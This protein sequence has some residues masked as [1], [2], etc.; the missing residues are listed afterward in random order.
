MAGGSIT[1]VN[2]ND[3]KPVVAPLAFE[4]IGACLREAGWEVDVLDLAFADDAEEAIAQHFRTCDPVAVGVT[5]RNT[6]DCYFA[7]QTSC[8]PGAQDAVSRIKSHTDAPV[9]LGG[10]G[11]SLM[12]IAIMT[13]C[14]VDYGIQGE[15]EVALP[16]L[17]RAIADGDEPTDIPGVIWRRE[18]E[19]VRTPP[20][21]PALDGLPLAERGTVDNARYFREGGM[22]GFETKR[23]CNRK[24][25]YCAD[26]VIKGREIRLR[27]PASVADELE[28]LLRLGIT[29]FHTCDSEFNNQYRHALAVCREIIDRGLGEKI[30]WY[31]YAIPRPF[32][33]ELAGTMKRAGCVGINFGAD[34]GSARMLSA[35]GRDFG[36]EDLLRTAKICRRQGIACMYDLL[37]GGPGETRESVGESIELM[38]EASP[39]RVGVA[40]G[41]RIYPGTRLAEMVATQGEGARPALHGVTSGN[42]SLAFPLFYVDPALGPEVYEYLADL[43][44]DDERFFLPGGSQVERDYDYSD[45][46]LLVQAIADGER[47]AFWDILRRLQDG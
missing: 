33:H 3:M 18:G 16:R 4:Y 36:P 14:G 22:A 1:L 8:L 38:R 21:P 45:N 28:A 31:A 35:L 41:I 37:L 34:S 17:V 2:A 30:R 9:I 44:G 47:G 20:E 5:I 11:F 7:S 13:H 15:G 32:N 26:P 10:C 27:T 40:A 25:I 24:C 12:P 39:D 42:E 29:H 19:F 6:D 23:G 46:E 43:V